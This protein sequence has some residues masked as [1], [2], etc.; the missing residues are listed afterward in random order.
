[1]PLALLRLST[2]IVR[3]KMPPMMLAAGN[4]KGESRK[5]CTTTKVY[6]ITLITLEHPLLPTLIR[7][8]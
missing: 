3:G 6:R 4:E 1:M 5:A 2:Y 7:K 8:R